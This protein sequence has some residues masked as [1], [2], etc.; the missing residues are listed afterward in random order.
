MRQYPADKIWF[1]SDLHI[2][3]KA[4]IP[5]SQR[6]YSEM[7]EMIEDMISKWNTKV[8]KD[9]T[10]FILGDLAYKSSKKQITN[11]LS[12]LNGIKVLIR[13]NHDSRTRTPLEMFEWSAMIETILVVDGEHKRE[14]EMCHY[15]LLS[16]G[17]MRHGRINL[18]GHSHGKTPVEK[19]NPMQM[20]IGWDVKY[21]LFSWEEIIEHLKLKK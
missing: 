18:F 20:D 11:F 16:W 15:P 13:G 2:G 14:V 4:V 1:T 10:V 6:P 8:K 17:N 3:H 19:I 9:D 12:R 7:T 5:M 21:D